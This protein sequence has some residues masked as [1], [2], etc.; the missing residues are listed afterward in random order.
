MAFFDS[1]SS[2]FFLDDVGTTEREITDSMDELDGLP[3][4][5]ALDEVTTFNDT[6][7]KNVQGIKRATITIGGPW[8]DAATTGSDVVLGGLFNGQTVTATFKYGPKG[9]T[10][11]FVRYTGECWLESY[12]PASR[13]GARV[14][15]RATL[16]VDGVV[17]RDTF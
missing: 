11:G 6:G 5:I 2:V 4:Q 1:K 9:D 10:G 8:N 3:G 14:G 13:V 17:T 15:W 12:T 7:E 16:R